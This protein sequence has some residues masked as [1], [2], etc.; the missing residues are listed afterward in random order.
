M[1]LYCWI[2]SYDVENNYVTEE[3]VKNQKKWCHE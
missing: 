2:D 1:G 3:K